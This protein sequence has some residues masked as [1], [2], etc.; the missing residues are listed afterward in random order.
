MRVSEAMTREVRIADPSQTI[1]DAAIIMTLSCRHTGRQARPCAATVRFARS[2]QTRLRRH[3]HEAR[4][5]S[6]R[7]SFHGMI[8]S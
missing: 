5:R 8:V 6:T 1:R 4:T 2:F 7:A 3:T